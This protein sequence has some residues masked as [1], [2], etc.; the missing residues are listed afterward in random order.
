MPLPVSTE[1]I[2][3]K[4][5]II[6]LPWLLYF[7]K[8]VKKTKKR[9]VC[10][11]DNVS[12]LLMWSV[13][14]WQTGKPHTSRQKTFVACIFVCLLKYYWSN[15]HRFKFMLFVFCR[16]SLEFYCILSVRLFL[17]AIQPIAVI[18]VNKW[19]FSVGTCS[20]NIQFWGIESEIRAAIILV[21][22]KNRVFFFRKL[23]K[24]EAT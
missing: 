2:N 22:N 10:V 24:R 6:Y 14:L 7:D 13:L 3:L 5:I 15:W 12:I 16:Q 8:C 19:A 4:V 11:I 9:S 20:V 1:C 17:R 18:V 21:L 23:H